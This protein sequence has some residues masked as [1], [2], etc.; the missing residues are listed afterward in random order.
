M[1]IPDCFMNN[2]VDI[3]TPIYDN[4]SMGHFGQVINLYVQNDALTS[5][6][7]LAFNSLVESL[8]PPMQHGVRTRVWYRWYPDVAYPGLT[9][10]MR[11]VTVVASDE[12]LIDYGIFDINSVPWDK[13]GGICL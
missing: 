10:G 8:P 3:D 13:L 11:D 12:V 5:L 9:V 7:R 4:P 6:E 2:G 1:P